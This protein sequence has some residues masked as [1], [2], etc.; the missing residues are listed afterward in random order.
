[1]DGGDWD[2]VVIAK[3]ESRAGERG[4]RERAEES[5]TLHIHG[6]SQLLLKKPSRMG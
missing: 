5:C 4:A 3:E 6:F 1:M 2:G